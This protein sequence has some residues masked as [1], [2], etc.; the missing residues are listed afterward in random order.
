M[1]KAQGEG[2]K[3]KSR[4]SIEYAAQRGAD[5]KADNW[6]GWTVDELRNV[7]LRER[8][9]FEDVDKRNVILIR[10]ILSVIGSGYGNEESTRLVASIKRL[11]KWDEDGEERT[12]ERI[13]KLKRLIRKK[14]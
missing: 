10:N 11:I 8:I 9:Y 7:L 2:R 13:R 6:E 5:V 14:K 4:K 1:K 3:R 12:K